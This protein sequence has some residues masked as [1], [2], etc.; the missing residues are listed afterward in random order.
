MSIEDIIKKSS[1]KIF[2]NA[3]Q[4]WNHSFFWNCLTPKQGAP[5]KKLTDALVKQFGG[6]EDFK[7]QFTETAVGTRSEEPTSEIQSLMRITYA[8]LCLKKKN[9]NQ[10]QY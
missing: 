1:G 8:V 9:T 7:K 10:I 6:V 4:V 3:A 5:G 2:N